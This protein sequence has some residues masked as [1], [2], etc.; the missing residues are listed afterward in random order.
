MGT[1][2]SLKPTVPQALRELAD[3]LESDPATAGVIVLAGDEGW[4]QTLPLGDA[5]LLSALGLLAFGKATLIE[6]NAD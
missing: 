5:G 6:A 3:K 4:V 1:V 2:T